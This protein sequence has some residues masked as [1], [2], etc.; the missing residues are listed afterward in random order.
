MFVVVATLVMLVVGE[1]KDLFLPLCVLKSLL[2]AV[3]KRDKRSCRAI[4]GIVKCGG[5]HVE[6]TYSF[7]S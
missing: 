6:W 4:G 5:V 7:G 2:R 3:E 1:A